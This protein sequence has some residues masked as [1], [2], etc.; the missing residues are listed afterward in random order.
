MTP[1]FRAHVWTSASDVQTT[2]VNG[3]TGEAPQTSRTDISARR[4][5]TKAQAATTAAY[6]NNRQSKNI[7]P[8]KCGNTA[9]R[10]GAKNGLHHKKT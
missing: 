4:M 1:I 3:R 5:K 9:T 10:N 6:G 7:G 8:E 2:T